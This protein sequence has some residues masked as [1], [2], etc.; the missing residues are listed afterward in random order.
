MLYKQRWCNLCLFCLL[1]L[2]QEYIW[3]NY[4]PISSTICDIYHV[5]EWLVGSLASVWIIVYVIMAIPSAI[6]LEMYGLRITMLLSAFFMIIGSIVRLIGALTTQFWIV[7]IGQLVTSMCLSFAYQSAPSLSRIWFGENERT[8]ST[9]LCFLSAAIGNMLSFFTVPFLIYNNFDIKILHSVECVLCIIIGIITY[10]GFID[11]PKT[12][13]SNA[14]IDRLD[15]VNNISPDQLETDVEATHITKQCG[16][17]RHRE[18]NTTYINKFFNHIKTIMSEPS[19]ILLM[20][21]ITLEYG[22]YNTLCVVTE[23]HLQQFTQKQVGLITG[24]MIIGGTVGVIS[25]S[26]YVDRTHYYKTTLITSCIISIIGCIGFLLV[27]IIDMSISVS[28]ST[29]MISSFLVGGSTLTSVSI[30]VETA[31]EIMYP[32]H[33][34]IVSSILTM[35]GSPFILIMITAGSLCSTLVIFVT[36]LS[37]C[38]FS[39]FVLVGITTNYLRSSSKL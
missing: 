11:H 6:I 17:Y 26:L 19:S 32:I 10:F 31:V 25:S 38:F 39:L 13:P 22:V 1:R 14:T 23:Q 33:E 37:A 9:G 36:N 8:M 5:S 2:L 18:R 35:I 15:I 20:G 3:I 29:A 34:G 12:P 16:C 21:S 27:N 4:S 28:F 30:G 7:W 24:L